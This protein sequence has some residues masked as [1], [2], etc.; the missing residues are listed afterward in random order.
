[1]STEFASRY[2][3]LFLVILWFTQRQHIEGGK[4]QNNGGSKK[5]FDV[6]QTLY[7]FFS[8]FY[9][10]IGTS[11]NYW[12]LRGIRGGIKGKYKTIFVFQ[13]FEI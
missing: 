1:M 12:V 11:T 5:G 3:G 6:T 10:S 8:L 7:L 4:N 2:V 13:E 9:Y